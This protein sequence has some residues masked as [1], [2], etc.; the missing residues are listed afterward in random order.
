MGNSDTNTNIYFVGIESFLIAGGIGLYKHSL[1]WGI[2]AFVILLI[3]YAIPVLGGIL[4]IISSAVEAYLLYAVLLKVLTLP[5]ASFITLFVF[6]VLMVVHRIFGVMGREEGGSRSFRYS[7]IITECF[8][9]STAVWYTQKSIPIACAVLVL[10]LAAAFIPGLRIPG[11]LI[12]SL[13]SAFLMWEVTH[14][15]IDMK[16]SILMALIV[17]IYTGVNHAAT[18]LGGREF[19]YI[20]VK[21][22]KNR[23]YQQSYYLSTHNDYQDVMNDEGKHGEYL[24]YESLKDYEQLGAK[25][26]FNCYLNKEDNSTTEIDVMLICHGGIFVFESKNYSGWI[27]GDANSLNWTQ[28]LP[29]GDGQSKK[30]QFYNPVK[31]N[32]THIKYLKN[33]IDSNIPVYSVIVFSDKCTLKD[34]KVDL[35]NTYVI[36]H[37]EIRTK[38]DKIAEHTGHKLDT[39]QIYELYN[40]LYPYTQVSHEMKERHIENVR[41]TIANVTE[42][43][44]EEGLP[45]LICPRC[46]SRLVLR[47]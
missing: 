40:K 10:L 1:I 8:V 3:V 27:F 46:G 20:N 47:T 7:L 33:L 42:P 13:G 14:D 29:I 11:L 31:Q 26:L 4:S 17:L 45:F 23:Y 19:E 25:F 37:N 41:K 35:V 12:L 15:N 32:R 34:V 22:D 6:Y 2:A 30:T 44:T 28:T 36:Q 43:E 24:I 16:Y 5:S 38:V 21:D 39:K 9:L 18:C